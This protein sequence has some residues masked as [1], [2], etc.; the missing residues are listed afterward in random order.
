VVLIVTKNPS[1]LTGSL[2]AWVDGADAG[3]SRN[4]MERDY[5]EGQNER[6]SS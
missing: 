1:G 3:Q 4:E 6:F 2:W 5:G